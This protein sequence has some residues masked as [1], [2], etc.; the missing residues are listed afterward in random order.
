MKVCT[1]SC[2][3][4]AW[5]ANHV[6][7]LHSVLDV[8]CGTGLL[9]LILKQKNKNAFFTAIDI[10]KNAAEEAA[11]NFAESQWSKDFLAVQSSI[12]S[13]N[14]DQK[15]DLVVSN[16][17]F[18]KNSLKSPGQALNDAKHE[19]HISLDGW[20]KHMNSHMSFGGSGAVLLPYER[21][22]ELQVILKDLELY[23]S[24]TA[25]VHH[26]NIHPAFRAMVIFSKLPSEE[27]NEQIFIREGKYYS[28]VFQNY[29]EPYYLQKNFE[30]DTDHT[31]CK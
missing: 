19:S 9:S 26:S 10:D 8:G 12:G 4:G 13:F 23:V 18:Y 5:V 21:Y 22:N 2:L 15:F 27:I 31:S 11:Y 17:P 14:T 7:N 1:D 30:K 24:R 16:P 6:A 3:F 20:I 28:E 25:I 29:L